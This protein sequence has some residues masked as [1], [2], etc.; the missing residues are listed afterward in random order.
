MNV[1]TIKLACWLISMSLTFGLSYYAYDFYKDFENIKPPAKGSPELEE[2]NNYVRSVLQETPD[3]TPEGKDGI[4]Y[5]EVTRTWRTYNWTGKLAPIIVETPDDPVDNT[6]QLTSVRTVLRL[7]M[8]QVDAPIPENSRIYV[9]YLDAR[10][11]GD[12]P[13]WLGPGDTLPEPFE[14]TTIVSITV[15]GVEFAH[16]GFDGQNEIVKP[17]DEFD[18][19]FIVVVGPDGVIQRPAKPGIPMMSRPDLLVPKETKLIGKNKYQI[20]TEDAVY[21]GENYPQIL[22]NDLRYRTYRNPKTGRRG[23]IEL[24]EV[25]AGSVA[26]RHGARSGDIIISVNDHAVTSVQEAVSFVKTNS[27][28]FSTWDVV[29]ENMGRRRTVTYQSPNN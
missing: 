9:A 20:G 2:A 5:P 26:E 21:L 23:G 1:S 28:R 13:V 25:R 24:Q 18:E 3:F 22:T 10:I 15:Q 6:P 8:V 19:S 16:A 12:A 17:G 4:T 27:E 29:V 11:A 7:L 14:S